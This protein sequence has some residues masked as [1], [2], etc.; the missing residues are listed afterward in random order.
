MP[1][2]PHCTIR[3]FYLNI[4][5]K[6]SKIVLHFRKFSL[7]SRSHVCRFICIFSEKE[8]ILYHDLN[9]TAVNGIKLTLAKFFCSSY[10]RVKST[11]F[12]ESP[13]LR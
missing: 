2:S 3:V 4:S 11:S 8:K 12:S 10:K 13:K 6:V 7:L 1:R 5:V 9:L